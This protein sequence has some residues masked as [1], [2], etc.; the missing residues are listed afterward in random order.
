MLIHEYMEVYK[1]TFYWVIKILNS[2][3]S[4]FLLIFL[5]VNF[6]FWNKSGTW[7]SNHM[8]VKIYNFTSSTF[9]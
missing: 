1:K 2:K 8:I 5:Y 7:P 3:I 6:L 9:I 4:F